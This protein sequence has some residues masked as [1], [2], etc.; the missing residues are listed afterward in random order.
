MQLTLVLVDR[1]VAV[2]L[3]LPLLV[4]WALSPKYLAVIERGPAAVAV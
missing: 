3:E 2:T 4:A 1:F